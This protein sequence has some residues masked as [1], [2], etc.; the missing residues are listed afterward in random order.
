MQPRRDPK[1]D[2]SE[3]F[4]VVQFS[5]FATIYAK[6]RHPSAGCSDVLKF[7]AI[8]SSAKFQM[9]ISSMAKIEVP[10]LASTRLS[11]GR[12]FLDRMGTSGSEAAISFVNW[13]RR[14]N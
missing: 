12:W 6:T 4:G 3:I 7:I 11:V 9:R 2:F 8:E 1:V 14:S 10:M 5:T 13:E